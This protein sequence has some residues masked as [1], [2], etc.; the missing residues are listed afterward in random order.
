MKTATLQALTGAL[1]LSLLTAAA[2]TAADTV[3]RSEK[4]SFRLVTLVNGLEH[5][6]SMAFL[7]DGRMLV[8][9][10]PGRLRL[11]GSDFRLMPEPVAGL[12][13]VIE[14]GQ[15]GLF[16]VV[17]H[18]DYASN[19]WIYLAYNGPGSGGYSTQLMRARLDGKRLI[20][21]EVLFTLMP[22]SRKG[23]HFGGPDAGRPRRKGPRPGHR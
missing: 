3:Y 12:P 2:A 5:P 19:G 4:H 14:H 23:Q 11:V 21:S 20:D 8:T 9:E 15:G 1:L 6:W 17:L 18:P 22:R 13:P 10:R 16:D 7:P